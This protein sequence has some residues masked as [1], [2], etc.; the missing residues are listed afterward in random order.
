MMKENKKIKYKVIACNKCHK[1]SGEKGVTLIKGKD[2]YYCKE[3]YNKL[4]KKGE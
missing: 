4:N 1:A 3:C 2:S